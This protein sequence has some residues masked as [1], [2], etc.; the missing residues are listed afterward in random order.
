MENEILHQGRITVTS[1]M[2]DTH[3]TFKHLKNAGITEAQAEVFVETFKGLADQTMQVNENLLLVR[4]ELRGEITG[5]H[6][7][8]KDMDHKIDSNHQSLDAK[9]DSNYQ[10]LDAKIDS[11]HQSLDAK[12]DSNHKSLDAK[13]D[14][15]YQSL[16]AK[17]EARHA[18][19]LVSSMRWNIG[20]FIGLAGLII[21]LD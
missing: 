16:D 19:T 18:Q 11:N 8:L 3:Q 15:N 12:I 5:I 6:L 10:K 4:D 7:K 17:A 21:A 13:I 14:S 20:M 1:P 9:I 2:D